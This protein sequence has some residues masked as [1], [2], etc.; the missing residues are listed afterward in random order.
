MHPTEGEWQEFL[1]LEANP[2]IRVEL[3]H[4]LSACSHCCSITVELGRR[5]AAVT[6][7]LNTLDAFGP[8]RTRFDILAPRR[9][10]GLRG[11]LWAAGIALC[12]VTA[13]SATMHWGVWQRAREW[14][15]GSRPAVDTTTPANQP[16]GLAAPSLRG[17]SLQPHG[18]IEVLFAER[19]TSGTIEIE[20]RDDARFSITASQPVQYSVRQGS[21]AVANRGV[22][23]SYRIIIPKALREA[24]V[25]LGD[26]LVCVKHGLSL[27]GEARL[28]GPGTYVLSFSAARKSL[29][30]ASIR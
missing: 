30:A 28:T 16:P 20:L 23:A 11:V 29:P 18:R 7:L 17:I 5:R 24:S 12:V 25:R 1:D 19:P 10:T 21:V 3:E 13:A 8:S 26:R 6:E 4:H 2:S 14:L 22:Q 15:L 27:S 9:R